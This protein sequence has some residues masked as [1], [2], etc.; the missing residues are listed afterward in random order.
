[1]SALLKPEEIG[2]AKNGAGIALVKYGREYIDVIITQV[3]CSSPIEFRTP[4]LL[5]VSENDDS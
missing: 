4:V 5:G 1:M 3:F 2:S